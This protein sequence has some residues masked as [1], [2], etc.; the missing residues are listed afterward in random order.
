M[1]FIS[2]SVF[3]INSPMLLTDP[4]KILKSIH[5]QVINSIS[6]IVGR[7]CK[8][9]LEGVLFVPYRETLYLLS[10]EEAL[11]VCEEVYRM[12]ARG[13][14]QWSRP[15]SWKLDVGAP[16]HNHWHVKGAFLSD[17]STTG[18]RMYN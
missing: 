5:R 12:H 11:E 8:V 10:I 6:F 3:A 9:S 7:L 17:I 14:A 4:W 16:W 1:W 2:Q 15:P 13:T 18:V